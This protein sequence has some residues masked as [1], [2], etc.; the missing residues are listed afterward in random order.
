MD[1]H[2]HPPTFLKTFSF[3]DQTRFSATIHES[4]F[5]VAANKS[6]FSAFSITSCDNNSPTT[7]TAHQVKRVF[8]PVLPDELLIRAGESLTLVQSFDDGWC[9]VGRE[10]NLFVATPKCL[11]RPNTITGDGIELGVVPAWCFIRPTVGLHADRPIRSTS[12]GITQLN[13]REVASRDNIVSWSHL[14]KLLE[15]TTFTDFY[16]TQQAGL[17]NDALL[18]ASE[19]IA[20]L[21]IRKTEL[22]H[23]LQRVETELSIAKARHARLV[24][25][26]L[27]VASLPNEILSTIFL[28]CHGTKLILT[29]ATA[30]PFEVV[31]SHVST[32]WRSV[33][34]GT[35]SLWSAIN[36]H[37]T[38]QTRSHAL[39]RLS[40]QLTRSAQCLL[41][42]SLH[43]SVSDGVSDIL[44]HLVPHAERWFRVSI[45]TDQGSKDDIYAPF[46][47]LS[48]PNL[49]H[50]SLRIGNSEE[51]ND[52]PRTEYPEISSTIFLQGAPS[53]AFVRVAGK[54]VGNIYPPLATIRTFHVD[55]WPKN[56]LNVAQLHS[57]LA[58]LPCL[59]HLSL[60]G[61][62]I[63]LPRD[64]LQTTE[65]TLLPSL[66]SL[67]I[68]GNATPC[69]R[70]LSLL[71]LPKLESLSLQGVVTFDSVV[72][73]SLH[74]L[75]LTSCDLSS[76][77]LESL[78]RSFPRVTTLG[79]DDSTPDIYS[80]L[81]PES[82]TSISWP[83]LQTIS[84][85]RIPG[86]DVVP[87]VNACLRR[88]ECGSPFQRVCLDRR[89]R[90]AVK[91]KGLLDGLRELQ[92]VE[93][94]DDNETWPS[95]LGYE[96]PDDTWY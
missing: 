75:T 37:V 51:N 35:A 87:F 95:D 47:P 33:A 89:T 1:D 15:N 61:L 24:N 93:N 49:I 12:L 23:E 86:I 83:V 90:T 52:T 70:L 85:R 78:P 17:P 57:L 2:H 32:H 68:R 43:L 62:S 22:L 3:P 77:D 28:L 94:V 69:F 4:I 14:Q 11:F 16:Q 8:E 73:P 6:R 54:V 50:L 65:P 9:L 13:S 59:V 18:E 67:R 60:T 84:L 56:L 21:E 19:K 80:L 45:S 41:D 5:R 63:H 10:N 7:G 27:P 48:V 71:S 29:R 66:R 20:T 36:L 25:Q 44:Y 81:T 30:R 76:V 26:A 46:Q 82:M 96:D 79:I 53:L 38:N 31:V 91:A 92:P 74:N 64:P 55:A 88:L 42:I 58:A 34:L 40:A 39:E 72:I